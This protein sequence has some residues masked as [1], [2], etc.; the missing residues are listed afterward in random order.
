MF[1]RAAAFK[2]IPHYRAEAAIKYRIRIWIIPTLWRLLITINMLCF[3]FCKIF[4]LQFNFATK[5]VS[6]MFVK[7]TVQCVSVERVG[8]M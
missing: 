3:S 7:E 5:S 1:V 8:E 2:Q 4:M 6:E